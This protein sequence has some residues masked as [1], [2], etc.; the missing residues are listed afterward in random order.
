MAKRFMKIEPKLAVL[1]F[2][3]VALIGVFGANFSGTGPINFL[4]AVPCGFTKSYQ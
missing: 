4:L 1:Y 2:L 3:T